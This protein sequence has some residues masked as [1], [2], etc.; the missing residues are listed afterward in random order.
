MVVGGG[1]GGEGVGG[2]GGGGRLSEPGT[3][4]PNPA[5]KPKAIGP[6]FSPGKGTFRA[7]VASP[8]EQALPPAHP[9]PALAV[10]EEPKPKNPKPQ[11]VNLEP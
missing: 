8:A 3:P 7:K 6:L 11:T 9:F 5:P 1:G 4:P 2:R 10:A